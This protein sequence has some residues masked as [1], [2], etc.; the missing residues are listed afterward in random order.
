MKHFKTFLASDDVELEK[1]IL[2]WLNKIGGKEIERSAP[3]ICCDSE[4]RNVS[5]AVTVTAETLT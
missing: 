3:A 5:I 4:G 2:Q 1:F